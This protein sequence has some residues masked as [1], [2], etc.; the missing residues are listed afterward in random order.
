MTT[1]FEILKPILTDI[2]S[3][4]KNYL[5]SNLTYYNTYM[6][7]KINLITQN[8]QCSITFLPDG[9]ITID[10]EI[11][12][13]PDIIING[14]D[15]M[16]KFILQNRDNTLFKKVEEKGLI[17]LISKTP[18]GEKFISLVRVMLGI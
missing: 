8:D 4:I 9:K 14:D 13:L 18:K 3:L 16:L 12:V 11:D 17:N 6:P 5:S 10:H 1:L 15:A 2:E 7:L